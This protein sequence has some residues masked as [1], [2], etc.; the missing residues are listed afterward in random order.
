MPLSVVIPIRRTLCH[1]R[2]RICCL[3]RSEKE[4]KH[5]IWAHY[6]GGNDSGH[7][8]P[9]GPRRK[10]KQREE[11]EKN[12]N[13]DE[14]PRLQVLTDYRKAT[15]VRRPGVPGAGQHPSWHLREAERST[16]AGSYLQSN[17]FQPAM[18][19]FPEPLYRDRMEGY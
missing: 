9:S 2:I 7:L 8:Q 12:M 19:E 5:S 11:G 6:P 14:R 4:E 16:F 3:P 13:P 15:S 17:Q 10:E 18:L 1:F